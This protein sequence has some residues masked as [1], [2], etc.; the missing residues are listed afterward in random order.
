MTEAFHSKIGTDSSS[1]QSN[2]QEG[3]LR[4]PPSAFDGSPFI[5]THSKKA[6]D[7][8]TKQVSGYD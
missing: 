8:H 6:D 2:P 5:H 4:Y 1:E 7:A 3:P